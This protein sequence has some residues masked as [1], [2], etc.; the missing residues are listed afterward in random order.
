VQPP[1]VPPKLT[2][3]LNDAVPETLVESVAVTVTLEVPATVGV[4]EIRPEEEMFR[5][6]GRPVAL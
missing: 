4:P 5:L 2:V 3:Q 1:P 6:A